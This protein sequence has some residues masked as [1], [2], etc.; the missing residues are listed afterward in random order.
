MSLCFEARLRHGS[1]F[2]VDAVFVTAE[3]GVTALFGPSGC[4][5]TTILE[6]VA[7][8]RRPGAGRIAL[9]ERVLVDV[10]AGVSLP[11]EERR[12][13]FVFQDGRLF[14]HR[15]V[16]ENL[17]YGARRRPAR[18]LPFDDVVDLLE[19]RPL[20]ARRPG[21]LSGGERQR[22]AVGRA[23]LRGPDLLL[24][25]EPLAALDD[26]IK[27]RILRYLERVIDAFAIPALYVSHDLAEVRRLADRVVFLRDGRVTGEGDADA[28]PINV[29]PLED[30]VESAG[31]WWGKIGENRLRLAGPPPDPARAYA[32]FDPRDV[33]L[34]R[35]PV[36]GLSIRNR[37]AGRVEELREREGTDHVLVRID[38]GATVWAEVTREAAAELGLAPGVEVFAL[39]KASAVRG[40]A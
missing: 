8:L 31:G 3:R 11:P 24:L 12:I 4:G 30:V 39:V 16:A 25:D 34:A 17:V 18:T 14:P 7:G 19:L 21:S 23:L 38:A 28:A 29:V 20:L 9:G 33:V 32:R 6:M 26:A 27:G 5:K 2:E 13:G 35:G 37:L 40:M 15:T 22:T 1:G 36:D 10:A